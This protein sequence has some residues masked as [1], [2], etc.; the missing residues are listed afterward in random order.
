MPGAP[1]MS[2]AATY[3]GVQSEGV[4]PPAGGTG[5][6]SHGSFVIW[7]I[8][9]GVVVPAAVLGGLQVG[10]FQFVFRSR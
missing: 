10:G 6:P 9:L 5:A 3:Q 7:L 4:R 2:E 8:V 1:F